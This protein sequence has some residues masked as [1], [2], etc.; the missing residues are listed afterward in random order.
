VAPCIARAFGRHGSSYYL[1]SSLL[2]SR[3]DTGVVPAARRAA[4]DSEHPPQKRASRCEAMLA[5]FRCRI[6][7]HIRQML[8]SQRGGNLLDSD[9]RRSRVDGGCGVAESD[10]LRRCER[11]QTGP[12]SGTASGLSSGAGTAP[13]RGPAPPHPRTAGIKGGDDLI[14][15]WFAQ[16]RAKPF[17][18]RRLPSSFA[19]DPWKCHLSCLF[20]QPRHERR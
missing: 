14:W 5:V 12:L 13:V 6:A 1:P 18:S 15:D 20:A 7:V 16:P 4:L 3:A 19:L 17:L 9:E 11:S 2:P 8:A 10:R